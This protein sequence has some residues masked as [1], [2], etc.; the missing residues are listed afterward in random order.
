MIMYTLII[1]SLLYPVH[2]YIIITTILYPC[3]KGPMSG[4]PYIGPRLGGG[5]IFEIPLS[6]LDEKERPDKY[7]CNLH[8]LNSR[9]CY[10]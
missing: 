9:R 3:E 6:Q 10:Y 7:V 5:P 8:Y 2:N 4:A 1:C